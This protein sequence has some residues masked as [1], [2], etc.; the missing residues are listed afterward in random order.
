M[1]IEIEIK[2][3]SIVGNSLRRHRLL[4]GLSYR[5]LA[6]LA[7]TDTSQIQRIEKGEIS[8]TVSTLFKL[9]LALNIK[10]TQ[11]LEEE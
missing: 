2:A 9:A 4:S 7:F 1:S 10:P 8:P 11:L 6:T 3:K 5:K